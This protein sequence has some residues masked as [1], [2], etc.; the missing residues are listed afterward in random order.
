MTELKTQKS[1]VQFK[2][3]IIS[4]CKEQ[5]KLLDWKFLKYR[6]KDAEQEN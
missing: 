6:D 3:I 1:N 5:G 2:I 4:T